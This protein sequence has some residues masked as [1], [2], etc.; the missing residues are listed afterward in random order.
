MALQEKYQAVLDSINQNGG[1]DVCVS[2]NN[3][4]LNITATV[5]TPTEKVTVWNKIKE[6]GGESPTDLVADIRM[7]N[8]E[9]A[10][11]GT[12]ETESLGKKTYVVKSGD[13]LSKISKEMYGDANKYM[14]IFNANTDKLKDPD[15][16]QPG[17]E[18]NIP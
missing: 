3:G 16:I 13:T 12:P 6:V 15:S 8:S 10:S 7:I 17:Q 11:G 4:V 9:I 5:P 1:V 18:L 14:D 2:E